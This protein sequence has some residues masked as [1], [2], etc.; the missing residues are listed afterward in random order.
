[1]KD[2]PIGT[3]EDYKLGLKH[4]L[5]ERIEDRCDRC[6]Q[7]D[8]VTWIHKQALRFECGEKVYA[9]QKANKQ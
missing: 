9:A 6:G 4:G 3:I 8:I 2:L 7:I 5:F 1:V